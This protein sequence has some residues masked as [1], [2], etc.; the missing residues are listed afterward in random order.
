MVKIPPKRGYVY[1]VKINYADRLAKPHEKHMVVVIQNND[2]LKQAK[3]INVV[4]ITSNLSHINAPFNVPL[5]ANTLN[6]QPKESKIKCHALYVISREDLENGEFCG[7]IPSN[8]MEEI[9]DA[10]IFSLGLIES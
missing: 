2:M 9:D 10:I 4:I 8:I 6:N 7:E 3:D 5:P 1:K